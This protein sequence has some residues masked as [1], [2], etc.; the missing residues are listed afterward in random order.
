MG[1]SSLYCTVDIQHLTVGQT[2]IMKPAI[3]I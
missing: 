2:K 3:F 1:L